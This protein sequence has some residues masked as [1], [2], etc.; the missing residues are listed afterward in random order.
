MVPRGQ[1]PQQEGLG[2]YSSI[3]KQCREFHEMTGKVGDVVLMHPLMVHSASR[4]SLRIPRIITNPPVALKEPFNF[5]R[6][7]PEDYSLVELKTLQALGKD[8]LPGWKIVGGREAVIPNAWKVK[9]EMKRL[10]I[11]RLERL[12]EVKAY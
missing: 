9:E 10:E 12:K 6:E 11:E 4:N 3:V 8:G 1:A 7:R 5:D 2:F